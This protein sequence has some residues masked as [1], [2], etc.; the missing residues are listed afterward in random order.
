MRKHIVEDQLLDLE[1]HHHV[2]VELALQQPPQR[3]Q[4]RDVVSDLSLAASGAPAA[5]R[6]RPE[7]QSWR[8]KVRRRNRPSGPGLEGAVINH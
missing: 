4:V 8:I 6:H 5:R 7:E 2:P 1:V 3:F